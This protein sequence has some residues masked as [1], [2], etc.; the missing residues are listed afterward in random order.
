MWQ[1]E[2]SAG[3]VDV[4]YRPATPKSE[5][6]SESVAP[7]T[8]WPCHLVDAVFRDGDEGSW[9]SLRPMSVPLAARI[10]AA[11]TA[12]GDLVVA[13]DRQPES[14]LLAA[15]YL[16]RGAVGFVSSR[17]EAVRL[18]DR[19]DARCSPEQAAQITVHNGRLDRLSSL[20]AATGL[21]DNVR[22][23][24]ALAIDGGGWPAPPDH[25]G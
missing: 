13:A 7:L 4:E 3:L 1:S 19:L 25:D 14:V 20:D 24:V 21:S 10:I 9:S 5:L 18:V 16:G 12:G 2:V 15:A 23:V 22:L 11:F 17:A 8:I 6:D